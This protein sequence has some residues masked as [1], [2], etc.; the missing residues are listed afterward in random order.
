MSSTKHKVIDFLQSLGMDCLDVDF[1]Q[2][3]EYFI[4]QMQRGLSGQ[5]SCLDMIPTYVQAANEVPTNKKVIVADA[6]GTHFRVGTVY[7][8]DN[9]KAVIENLQKFSMP[10]IERSLSKVEFF[11]A[12]AEYFRHVASSSKQVGFCFSY[13]VE[14]FPSKDGR[15]IRFAKEI[16]AEEVIGQL[17]GENLIATM[18]TMNMQTPEKVVLLNDTVATLLAGVNY[19]NRLFDSYIGF[20]LGT[21]TNSAYIEQNANIKKL[22]DLD[23]EQTQIINM[24]SGA[25][26]LAK[27]G[28]LDIDFDATTANPGVHSFEKMISGAYLG[29]LS[30]FTLKRACEAGLFSKAVAQAITKIDDLDTRLTN[31]FLH[32]PYGD[33]PLAQTCGKGTDDDVTMAYWILNRLVERAA[34][35]AAINLSAAA[36]KSGKGTNPV[37]PICVLAEGTT[38]YQMK[39]LRT[40]IQYYLKKYLEDQRGVYVETV[41]IDNATLLGAAIAGLTN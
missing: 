9:K 29:P 41:S 20:I 7:F 37:R 8:D 22:S 16:K 36:I 14:M 18:D 11:E 21:G 3:V 15:V 26:M 39:T 12:M 23:C 30:L 19:Q 5:E 10:A 34:K 24:E 27:R 31:D 17:V 6:G 33:N 13:P 25:M 32:Y 38:F 4:D 1:D 2:T 35:F 28:Q 40:R